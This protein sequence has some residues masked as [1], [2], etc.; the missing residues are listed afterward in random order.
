[1][2]DTVSSNNNAYSSPMN[3]MHYILPLHDFE[4]FPNQRWSQRSKDNNYGSQED[5][6][7]LEIFLHGD[8]R[9]DRKFGSRLAMGVRQEEVIRSNRSYGVDLP[10]SLQYGSGRSRFCETLGIDVL[11]D[12]HSLF[13]FSFISSYLGYIHQNRM[14]HIFNG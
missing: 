9:E 6:G 8:S 14:W 3:T 5:V 10:G 7:S 4:Y 13:L 11:L 1:M 12:K 2:P